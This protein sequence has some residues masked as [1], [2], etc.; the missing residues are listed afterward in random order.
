MLFS[1]VAASRVGAC[2]RPENVSRSLLLLSCR[3]RAV[4]VTCY[5]MMI[6]KLF[7]SCVC[8]C[9]CR[10]SPY[11]N[12]FST[13]LFAPSMSLTPSKHT[14]SRSRRKTRNM[15]HDQQNVSP[16]IERAHGVHRPHSCKCVL[17]E[18][19]TGVILLKRHTLALI[20]RS[21][22]RFGLAQLYEKELIPY[23]LELR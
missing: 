15:F 1:H 22:E 19:Y 14:P 2:A 12:L 8:V 17:F 23:Q 11:T 3:A 7:A 21:K 18:A 5:T 9:P 4:T 16:C 13:A 6:R 10:M 20:L